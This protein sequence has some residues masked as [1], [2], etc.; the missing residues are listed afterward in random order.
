MS[1]RRISTCS[2][3]K[4]T[5]QSL[6]TIRVAS[7]SE[8]VPVPPVLPGSLS[9]HCLIY[10]IFDLKVHFSTDYYKYKS[11]SYKINAALEEFFK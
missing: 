10:L 4:G 6:A 3:E 7:D 9:R 2:K 8:A 11:I 5:G 1:E